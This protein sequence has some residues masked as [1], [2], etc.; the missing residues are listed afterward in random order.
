[1]PASEAVRSFAF[2]PGI[3]PV[4]FAPDFDYDVNFE[5]TILVAVNRFMKALN[6]SEI[7]NNLSY[8]KPLF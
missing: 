3:Y 4:E 5:K 2:P 8:M 6:K 1:M 7:P